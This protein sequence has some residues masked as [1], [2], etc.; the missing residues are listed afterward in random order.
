MTEELPT[1][2]ESDIGVDPWPLIER[3]CSDVDR[4]LAARMKR[5]LPIFAQIHVHEVIGGM[6]ARQATLAKDV[7]RAP[8]LWTG[9]SAPICSAPWQM[10]TSPSPGYC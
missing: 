7:A 6:L 10:P 2:D 1:D 3:Y 5:G 4:E 8:A 9:H